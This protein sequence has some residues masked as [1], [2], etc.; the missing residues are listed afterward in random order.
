MLRSIKT[1]NQSFLSQINSIII[2]DT[3]KILLIISK[4]DIILIKLHTNHKL[5]HS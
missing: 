4:M 3:H 5:L 2:K 1:L